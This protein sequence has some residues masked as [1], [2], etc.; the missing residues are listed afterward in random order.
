MIRE[1]ITF[2]ISERGFVITIVAQMVVIDLYI[3]HK[4]HYFI[5]QNFAEFCKNSM[6][7]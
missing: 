5:L 1:Q 4:L 2:W 7:I 6:N 3:L